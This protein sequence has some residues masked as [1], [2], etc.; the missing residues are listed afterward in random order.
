MKLSNLL[1]AL[2]LV[3][4]FSASC[5]KKEDK[6][7]EKPT[8]PPSK[9]AMQITF[10][11]TR[12]GNFEIYTMN[13]D[14]TNVVRLTR[15][16]GWSRYPAWSP[17]G[18]TILFSSNRRHRARMELFTIS[19]DSA[20]FF[21]T[22]ITDTH[23]MNTSAGWSPDGKQIVCHSSRTG[24]YEIWK[25]NADGSE[26]VNISQSD[27]LEDEPSWSPDG[28]KIAYVIVTSDNASDIWVMN[29]DGSD[30]KQLTHGEKQGN[31]SPSWSPDGS[32]I[33][34]I[35]GN[36][37]EAQVCIMNADGSGL[38][39][40]TSG[41]F[42]KSRPVWSPDGSRIAFSHYT[43]DTVKDRDIFLMNPD[44]SNVVD[45]TNSPGLDDYPSWSPVRK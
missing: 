32:R 42:G 36:H 33:V 39:Q 19:P 8:A 37:P 23:G 21:P 6:A 16:E 11:S 44:G 4:F 14:G 38:I 43:G 35:S 26:A 40:L 45:I 7:A 22:L 18:N 30:K 13:D 29:A 5:G 12:D 10:E 9:T 27:K 41:G 15:S 20:L 3:A 24:R 17:N 2:L 25:M 28:Q 34:F 31:Y 1:P